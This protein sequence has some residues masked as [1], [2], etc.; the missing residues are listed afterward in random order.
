MAFIQD[1]IKVASVT[2][3]K[4]LSSTSTPRRTNNAFYAV[5][6]DGSGYPRWYLYV[7]G[8]SAT[9]AL[10]NI[11]SPND[12]TGRFLTFYAAIGTQSALF[13]SPSSAPATPS[14]ARAIFTDVADGLT[15]TRDASNGPIRTLA[16]L[17]RLQGYSA[18]QYP[19]PVVNNSATGSVTLDGSAS[20][21]FLLTLTG[22]LT[23][24]MN[25]V[26]VGAT[27]IIYLIEDNVGGAT[28]T[29]NAIFKR[30]TGDTSTFNTTAN[31]VNVMTC[32]ARASNALTVFPIAVEV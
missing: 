29:L 8:S 13:L 25:N 14:T 5:D 12:T 20:N 11:V 6:D 26:Q 3:L 32:I 24:T 31:K 4:A 21:I 23:L 2:A 16:T 30:I 27:Y 28:I 18:T 19:N 15:K 22:N 17:E 1:A 9:E 10:P 7:A